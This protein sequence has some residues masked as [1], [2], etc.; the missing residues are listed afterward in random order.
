MIMTSEQLF[1]NTRLNP[2]RAEDQV[3]LNA[4]TL[5]VEAVTTDGRPLTVRARFE[6]PLEDPR[7]LFLSWRDDGYTPFTPPAVDTSTTLPAAD[8]VRVMYGPGS[9]VTQWLRIPR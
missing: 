1:R 8:L 4:A 9:P 3:A 2:F 5:T 7:Y 6:R